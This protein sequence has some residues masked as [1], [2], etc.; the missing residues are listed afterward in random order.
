MTMVLLILYDSNVFK[1]VY[2]I[3]L[4][5]HFIL[6]YEINYVLLRC[7]STQITTFW[8]RQEIRLSNDLIVILKREL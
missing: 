7:N 3:I 5:I 2:A 1:S 8:L 4:V 6:G